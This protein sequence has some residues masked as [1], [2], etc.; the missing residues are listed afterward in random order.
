MRDARTSTLPESNVRV[1]A[2]ARLTFV[3]CCYGIIFGAI[4][5]C[6]IHSHSL[7]AV[8]STRDSHSL[9]GFS[10]LFMVCT[11]R[12]CFKVCFPDCTTIKQSVLRQGRG[13]QRHARSFDVG[14]HSVRILFEDGKASRASLSRHQGTSQISCHR[15][16]YNSLT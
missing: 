10:H 7:R 14:K 15:Q 13:D 12:C 3:S 2:N 16:P 4:P 8:H 6:C 1:D 9:L 5:P 11:T